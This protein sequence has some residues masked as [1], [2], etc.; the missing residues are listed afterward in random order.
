MATFFGGLLMQSDQRRKFVQLAV[1]ALALPALCR[2]AWAINYPSRPVRIV[3]GFPAGGAHDIVARLVA[4]GLSERLGQPVVIEN[5]AGAA[6]NLATESVVNAAPDGHS[7]IFFGP[8]QAI[9]ATLYKDLR[10]NFLRDIA[11]VASIVRQPLVMVVNP[12]LPTTT[13]P[14][15]M[16]YAKANPGKLNMAGNGQGGGNHLAGELFKIATGIDMLTVQYRG[17]APALTDLMGG[18]VQV[19]FCPVTSSIELIRAGKV[20]ALSIS[21]PARVSLLPDLPS[22]AD[23][24]P[25]Y[26]V[27]VVFGLGVPRATPGEIIEK[28]NSIITEVTNDPNVRARIAELG[29]EVLRFSPEAYRAFVVQETEKW[30]KVIQAAD[31]K[32]E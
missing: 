31:I 27:S 20:R 17:D 15:F 12:S 11:P 3:V 32:L 8:P 18:Q 23:F 9:N 1:G 7:L 14:E 16:A 25:G 4:P 19:Y 21:G 29:G 28:L 24:V 26:D 22:I 10:Y 2:A 5:K 13:M 6:T 30:A